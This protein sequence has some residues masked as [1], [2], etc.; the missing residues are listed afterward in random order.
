METFFSTILAGFGETIASPLANTI[1]GKLGDASPSFIIQNLSF[2]LVIF[3]IAFLSNLVRSYRNCW[4]ES[5]G[6][7][8]GLFRGL[9]IGTTCSLIKIAMLF[10]VVLL[11]PLGIPPVR[12]VI[13]ACV[14]LFTYLFTY[15]AYGAC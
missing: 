14:Y 10:A 13:I 12:G 1:A 3:M 2:F 6:F 8:Y 11:A 5:Y 7:Q 9:I 4:K 15:P